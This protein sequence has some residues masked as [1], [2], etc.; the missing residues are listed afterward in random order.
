MSEIEEKTNVSRST[1]KR[2][3]ERFTATGSLAT[4]GGQHAADPPNKKMTAEVTVML[5][6]RVIADATAYGREHRDALHEQAGVNVH[7]SNIYT[8]LHHN[9]LSHQQVGTTPRLA[10][11]CML[12]THSQASRSRSQITQ[13]G[14]SC[15]GSALLGIAIRTRYR[16]DQMRHP[17]TTGARSSRTARAS[18]SSSIFVPSG[19]LVC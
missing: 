17:R 4:W 6:Q 3:L 1:Q 7:L 11:E 8:A 12:C 14:E 2:T 19:M 15:S 10:L 9:G 13:V 5:R 16:T 18:R